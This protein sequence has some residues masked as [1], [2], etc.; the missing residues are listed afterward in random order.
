MQLKLSQNSLVQTDRATRRVGQNLVNCCKTTLQCK[1][2][3]YTTSP[4]QIEA[5]ELE[6]WQSTEV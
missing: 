6:G 4:E 2:N 3:L 5:V 1:N